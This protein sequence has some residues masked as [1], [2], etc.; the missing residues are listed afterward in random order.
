MCLT[1][2]QGNI[3]KQVELQIESENAVKVV[4][5]SWDKMP[6][7]FSLILAKLLA[8]FGVQEDGSTSRSSKYD[9]K[10]IQI[11]LYNSQTSVDFYN[12]A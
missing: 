10:S 7:D 5:R 6:K 4:V 8:I 11:E 2:S 12:I 9:I 1:F 3:K